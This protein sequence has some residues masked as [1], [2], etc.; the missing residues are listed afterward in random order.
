MEASPP[1]FIDPLEEVLRKTQ[2][3]DPGVHAVST[4]NLIR[5]VDTPHAWGRPMTSAGVAALAEQAVRDL[6]ATVETIIA[7]ATSHVDV[8]SL[9]TPTGVFWTAVRNGLRKL[10]ERAAGAP[11]TVRFLFGYVPVYDQV[12]AF[13]AELCAFCSEARLPMKTMTVL[14]GRLAPRYGFTWNHAKIVAA[15]GRMALVGGHNLWDSAYGTY[16]PVHDISVQ[17][18]GDAAA[19]ARLFADFLWKNGGTILSVW[20]VS[21]TCTMTPLP[22]DSGRE[23]VTLDRPPPATGDKAIKAPTGGGFVEGR[24]L[25]LGRGGALGSSASDIAKERI[26]KSAQRTLKFC[27][28]DL[29]FEGRAG[30]DRHQVCVWIAEA[31]LANPGLQVSIVVSPV[32]GSG[33][34]EPY[35]W[36]SGA[37]GTFDMLKRLITKKAKDA[38]EIRAVLT[39]LQVAPFCFTALP[40]FTEGRDYVWP[41][42]PKER[43]SLRMSVR[44]PI[45]SP[46]GWRTP[47][48]G[49]HAKVFI[50]DDVACYVGSDNLYPHNLM[51]FG[52]LIEGPAAR[53]IVENYWNQVWRYSGPHALGGPPKAKL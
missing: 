9:G 47:A 18:F 21:E 43:L 3:M 12:E 42:V 2:D 13:K 29:L 11:V 39:R 10:A 4:G 5:V 45:P 41:E 19:H 40:P 22:F 50:A 23:K 14:V 36:G 33:G 48:P 34:G 32:D 51:E 1:S 46:I 35:S 6:A 25:T 26:I 31:L 38:D 8:V 7:S 49:N 15:D 27:Q 37:A 53:A 44:A 16:P 28:Q 30:D 17:V 52:Y 24:V 20:K